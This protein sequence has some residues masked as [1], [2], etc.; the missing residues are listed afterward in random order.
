MRAGPVS[1]SR[2]PDALWYAEDVLRSFMNW[3]GDAGGRDTGLPRFAAKF[4][5]ASAAVPD[6][7]LGNSLVLL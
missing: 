5:L 3:R 6:L 1:G 7:S 2:L 4:Q